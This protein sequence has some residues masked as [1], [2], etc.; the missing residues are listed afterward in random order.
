MGPKLFHKVTIFF[1][2]R[3]ANFLATPS[4]NFFHYPCF[5]CY[6]TATWNLHFFCDTLLHPS[7]W[8]TLIYPSLHVSEFTSPSSTFICHLAFVHPPLGLKLILLLASSHLASC[9]CK[10]W[11]FGAGTSA[12]RQ[13]G[14]RAPTA[15]FQSSCRCLDESGRMC[16]ILL[17]QL[18]NQLEFSIAS[19]LRRNLCQILD[20]FEHV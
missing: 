12:Q 16:W 7:M 13:R 9:R 3:V 14:R 11:G 8:I 10:P 18:K 4:S 1:V 20:R 17:R 5:T 6:R 15:A 19:M 2:P